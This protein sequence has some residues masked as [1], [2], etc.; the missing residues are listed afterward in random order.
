MKHPLTV[1]QLIVELQKYPPDALV[2]YE[3]DVEYE[4]P[5]SRYECLVAFENFTW[6][7]QTGNFVFLG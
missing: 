1:A 2:A 4:P 7:R 3:T 6:V 5:D